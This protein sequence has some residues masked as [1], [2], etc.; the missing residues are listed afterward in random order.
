VT[1]EDTE[2]GVWIIVFQ[3]SL[4]RCSHCDD[5]ECREFGEMNIQVSILFTEVFSL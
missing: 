2:S 5:D 1:P 3:S 4:P